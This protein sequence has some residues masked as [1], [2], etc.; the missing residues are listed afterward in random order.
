M[1]MREVTL[2]VLMYM[3]PSTLSM[4]DIV[5]TQSHKVTRV[6]LYLWGGEERGIGLQSQPG[7]VVRSWD[8]NT[9]IPVKRFYSENLHS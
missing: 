8:G 5:Y 2:F 3:C 7:Q 9:G 1:D 4:R 6:L